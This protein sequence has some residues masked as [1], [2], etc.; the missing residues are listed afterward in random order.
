M[1]TYKD[2]TGQKFNRLTAVKFSRHENG[3][4]FWYFM[5]DCGKMVER[6]IGNVKSGNTKSCG[7]FKSEVMSEYDRSTHGL[8]NTHFWNAFH[9]ARGRCTSLTNLDYPDYGGRGIQ[10]CWENIEDFYNDM[11]DTYFDGATLEREAVDGNYCKENC[12]WETR[13]KQA[14]NRRKTKANTSGVTGVSFCV[15]SRRWVAQWNIPEGA[16]KSKSFSVQ[17]YGYDE[18]FR[19]ACEARTSAIEFLNSIGAGYS[20]KHGL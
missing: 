16:A 18:S 12:K 14:R 13:A 7:C 4:T 11:K 10:F 8:F 15:V 6:R 3:N 17:K 1:A 9:G 2:I 20:K 19:L 5:C